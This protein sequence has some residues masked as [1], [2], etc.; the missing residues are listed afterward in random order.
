[1]ATT[2]KM[3]DI[4]ITNNY[5]SSYNEE[6]LFEM[7]VEELY[8]RYDSTNISRFW[9]HKY[10]LDFDEEGI[11]YDVENKN[12]MNLSLIKIYAPDIY[13]TYEYELD[14]FEL[15][16]HMF[17]KTIYE[18]NLRV[19]ADVIKRRCNDRFFKYI[20]DLEG[21]ELSGDDTDTDEYQFIFLQFF[22]KKMTLNI[23]I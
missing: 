9:I 3:K 2:L 22:N 16:E 7:I 20:N 19:C 13:D 11:D 1:M 17:D 4:Q 21:D 14:T 6:L 10:C 5:Y 15:E 18:Y 23:Y 8:D 12:N